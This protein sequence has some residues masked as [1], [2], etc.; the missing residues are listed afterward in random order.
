MG[1]VVL[2]VG[3]CGW[4]TI[5]I[6]SRKNGLSSGGG[7]ECMSFCILPSGWEMRE[8]GGTASCWLLEMRRTNGGR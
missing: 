3:W 4:A 6:A 5:R 8:I 1:A 7:A 2:D